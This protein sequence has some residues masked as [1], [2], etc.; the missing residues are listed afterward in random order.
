MYKKFP[1][2]SI[3]QQLENLI[4]DTQNK[5]TRKRRTFKSIFFAQDVLLD[6]RFACVTHNGIN[7]ERIAMKNLFQGREASVQ[8][9]FY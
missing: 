2:A 7:K 1:N 3:G 6:V 9:G 4:V 5:V 8:L